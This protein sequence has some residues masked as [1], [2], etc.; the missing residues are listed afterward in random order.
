M[1]RRTVLTKTAKGL[2]EVTGKTSLLPRD[3]RN[4]LSQVDG[5]A[6]VGDLHQKLDK[7]SEPKLIETL[8]K[9]VRDGFVREFV[10]APASVSPPSQ[11]PIVQEDMDLDFT[12]LMS[13]PPTKA[14]VTAQTVAEADEVARQVAEA[15]GKQD[16]GARAKAEAEAR[17]K[18]EAEEKA[19]RE[20]EAKAKAEAEARAKA[21][22]EARAKAEAEARAKREAEER[23]RKEAEQKARR[24][25]EAKAKAEAEARAKAEAE[26]RAKAEA[27]A[28]ARREAEERARKEAE[29]KA[30]REAEAKAKAE[31]EARAKAEAEARAKAEAEARAKRDAEE[32][33]RREAEAKAKAEAEARAKAKAEA[34]ARA[35]A[36]AE[37]RA[38]READARAKREADER[39][40]KEA[41][42][43]ARR[44]A[45]AKAKAEAEA[46]AK[47]EAEEHA[48]KEAEEKA[49]REAEARRKAEAEARAR[50]EAEEKA[51]RD[52]AER[53]RREA[54][55]R[56]RR[57][58]EEQAQREAESRARLEADARA[59]REAEERGQREQEE[60]IRREL[61]D[62][63][64]RAEEESRRDA[65]E[66]KRRDAEER[67]R[68]EAEAQA[69]R[70]AEERARRE[71]EERTRRETEERTRREAEERARRE[72]EEVA[73]REAEE[74]ARRKEEEARSRQEAERKARDD[75]KARA[76]AD[77]EAAARAR[78]DER[79]REK[80]DADARAA[81]RKREQEKEAAAVSARLEKIRKGKKPSVGKY[82][83]I[84]AALAVIGGLVYLQFMPLDIPKYERLA[85]ARF[86]QPVKIGGGSISLIPTP[87][88]R[89]ENVAI[90]ANKGVKIAVAAGHPDFASVFADDPVLKSIDLTGV[91]LDA[92]GLAGVLWGRTHGTA[93]G[94]QQINATGVKIVMPGVNLP[95]LTATALFQSDGAL[96]KLTVTNTSKTMSAEIQP[97]SGAKANVELTVASAAELLGL[98]FGVD[99][100]SARGVA[101]PGEFSAAELEVK[102]LDGVARGKGTLRWTGG[103][104]A[105]DG[106]LEARSLDA[107]RVSPVLAGRLQGPMAVA[108]QGETLDKLAAGSRVDWSFS[109]SKGHISGVD[110]P[111]TLQSGK[112]VGGETVFNEVTGQA[113][114]DHGKVTLRNVKIDAGAF[115]ANG[116][117]DVVEGGKTIAGRFNADMKTPGQTLRA[118][119]VVSGTPTQLSVKR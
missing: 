90:G 33:A 95:E 62:R 61:E 11:V 94:I 14:E 84:L 46:R 9:L 114:I 48:R 82:V 78:R 31:A 71:A 105:F 72:A 15:R 30:R 41:E 86:G 107:K 58:A 17:A 18:R 118:T 12:A 47:R 77:A 59:R 35:K 55:D 38:K 4:V 29:E 76:K 1:D 88:V 85:S 104:L 99:G 32:K 3:L 44:E 13:K 65:E 73:R 74:A 92:S 7:F 102:L 75:E 112:S 23:A 16:A 81:E 117:V 101:S 109:V 45:E 87:A 106:T 91:T 51:K 113:L 34:E 110:L 111:R 96:R 54:E 22:A 98:P 67:G 27:E 24:E 6:T 28:R 80:A 2:M 37:A 60:R 116:A 36:E 53:A 25:A 64:R 19:R 89:F 5:K 52:E 93:L 115:Q 10:S 83:G 21:E 70:E 57:A 56:V 68:R 66:R 97:H 63:V 43:K 26:A 103:P 79:A 69:R 100:F 20:A 119:L 39:A 42:E 49:R 50:R 40:R 108:A 8:G